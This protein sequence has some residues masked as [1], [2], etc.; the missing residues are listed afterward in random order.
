MANK[1]D[2]S[3]CAGPQQR[4]RLLGTLRQPLLQAI[5]KH[6]NEHIRAYDACLREHGKKS[7]DELASLCTPKLRGL[8]QC[9][10]AVKA[11]AV[12]VAKEDEQSSGSAERA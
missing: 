11:H 9:T 12:M 10:E 8:W 6:C 7:D 1:I 4:H 2:P 5:K 3:Q